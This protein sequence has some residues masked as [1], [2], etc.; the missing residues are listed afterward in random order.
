VGERRF[1]DPG[2]WGRRR[3]RA[4]KWLGRVGWCSGVGV[5]AERRGGGVAAGRGLWAAGATGGG[6]RQCE[7]EE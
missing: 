4:V 1:H 5:R 7:G 2:G 3:G 6:G